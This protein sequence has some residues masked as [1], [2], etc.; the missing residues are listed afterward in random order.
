MTNWYQPIKPVNIQPRPWLSDDAITYFESIL[1]PDMVVCEFGG[2]GSTL[3]MAER[4]SK[5][6]TCEPDTDWRR[7]IAKHIKPKWTTAP[8][9]CDLL[10]IDGEPVHERGEWLLLAHQAAR[11][12]VVLDN[13]NRPEY[14]DEREA[15]SASFELVFTSR[16]QAMHLVTEFWRRI[17]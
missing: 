9:E 2:G 17:D 16:Q 11:Q 6:Y 15:L 14:A 4:V 12:W 10:F 7:E 3:W 1:T 5:V 8:V 13:A